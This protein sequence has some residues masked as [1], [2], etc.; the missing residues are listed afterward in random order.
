MNQIC[1]NLGSSLAARLESASA[2]LEVAGSINLLIRFDP[3][4]IIGRSPLILLLVFRRVK[5]SWQA[6]VK[7]DLRFDLN[8]IW[9]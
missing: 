7:F 5:R 3:F 8:W 6:T 1:L 2:K 4:H 9:S